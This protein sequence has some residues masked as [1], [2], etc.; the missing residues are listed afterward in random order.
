MNVERQ[1]QAKELKGCPHCN[2]FGFH[3][4]WCPQVRWWRP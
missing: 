4:P 1:T 3:Q 2:R